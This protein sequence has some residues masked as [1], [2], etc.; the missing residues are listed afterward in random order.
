MSRGSRERAKGAVALGSGE[1]RGGA[2][3][4]GIHHCLFDVFLRA[5]SPIPCFPGGGDAYSTFPGR[6]GCHRA[7]IGRERWNPRGAGAGCGGRET[8][9]PE[10]GRGGASWFGIHHCLFGVFLRASLPI[11]PFPG[12]GDAYSTFPGRNGCHR[13]GI[14]RERW[15]PRGAGA[16]CGGRK[17]GTRAGKGNTGVFAWGRGR[18]DGIKPGGLVVGPRLG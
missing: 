8:W 5:S 15:N 18:V 4:F 9:N 2:S 17:G 12:D 14:G 16:G 3:W 7:G 11:P 1:G 6:N 13:A 10:D